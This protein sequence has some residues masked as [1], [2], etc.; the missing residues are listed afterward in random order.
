LSQKQGK[1]FIGRE[2][3]RWII[4]SQEPGNIDCVTLKRLL[5]SRRGKQ[6]GY[7]S[8]NRRYIRGK[9]GFQKFRV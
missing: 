9:V 4:A 1:V 8:K 5:M 3:K 2:N 6:A 7:P